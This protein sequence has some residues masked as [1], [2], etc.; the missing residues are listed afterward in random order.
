L[1][2]RD[3]TFLSAGAAIA[4]VQEQDHD[5]AAPSGEDTGSAPAT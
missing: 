2:F 3:G 5:G 4:M 1:Q